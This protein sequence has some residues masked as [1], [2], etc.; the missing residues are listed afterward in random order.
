MKNAEAKNITLKC[1]GA[2]TQ[3]KKV[4]RVKSSVE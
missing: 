4:C 1:H 3:P 2:T